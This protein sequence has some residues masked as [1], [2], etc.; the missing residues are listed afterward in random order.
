MTHK[1]STRSA[2]S[3]EL[4]VSG[5]LGLNRAPL[6]DTCEITWGDG[7][8]A[9]EAQVIWGDTRTIAGSGTDLLDLA[10][11]LVDGLGQTVTL[12]AVK[13]LWIRAASGNGGNLV[14][15]AA[16]SNT[17]VGPFGSATDTL[18]IPA[19]GLLHLVAPDASGWAVTADT[20]D[21]LQVANDDS[22]AASYSVI[23]RGISA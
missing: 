11:V 12:T 10:G 9:E 5:D 14:I 16:A 3:G 4:S 17:W 7:Q 8:D 18:S 2:V 13:E 6:R 23:L 21:Q 22:E 20:A 15:G 1:G 19:S